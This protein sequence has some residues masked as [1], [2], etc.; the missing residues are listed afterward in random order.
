MFWKSSLVWGTTLYIAAFPAS[1]QQRAE[2]D[3][4]MANA[5][6][7]S[8]KMLDCG[9][10]EIDKDLRLNAAYQTLM[11]RSEGKKLVSAIAAGAEDM[12]QTSF[13]RD[14]RAGCQPRHWVRRIPRIAV[15]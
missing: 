6:G 1:A 13:E 4:C 10:A 15:F 8:S 11:Q 7:V 2:F 3:A 14:P 12:A 5:D 9:K